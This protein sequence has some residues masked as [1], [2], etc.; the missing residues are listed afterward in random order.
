MLISIKAFS[1]SDLMKLA[2]EYPVI[3]VTEADYKLSKNETLGSKYKFWFQHQ[4]LG[5]CL[6]KQARQNLGEDWAEKV[7]SE[8]CEL[9]GLPHAIYELAETWEGKSWCC[10][11]LLF[12]RRMGTCSW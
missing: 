7:A 10:L 2:P 6:Y 4:E 3:F 1:V 11:T 9:L 8:L 12:A 5:R